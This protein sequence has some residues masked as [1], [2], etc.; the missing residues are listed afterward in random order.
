MD[1]FFS[2]KAAVRIKGLTSW[3][4]PSFFVLGSLLICCVQV[5]CGAFHPRELSEKLQMLPIIYLYFSI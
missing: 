2:W 3:I 4:S 5:S 1:F